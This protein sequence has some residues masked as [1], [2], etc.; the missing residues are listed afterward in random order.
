MLTAQQVKPDLILLD[1]LLPDIDGA[2]ACKMLK[3]RK[4]TRDIPV[5]AVTGVED[6]ERRSEVLLSGA[7]DLVSKPLRPKELAV[8]IAR[9]RQQGMKTAAPRRETLSCGNLKIDLDKMEVTVGSRSV[10]LTSIEVK[11]LSFFVRN[12]GSVISR[13]T[14]LNSIWKDDEVNDRV[15]DNRILTLRKKLRGFNHQFVTHYGVGY[16]LREK[17]R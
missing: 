5:I 1:I 17:K 4:E 10:K 12:K 9:L 16:S 8:R 6:D 2:L 13:E 7:D 3:T 14:L 11:L 15:V